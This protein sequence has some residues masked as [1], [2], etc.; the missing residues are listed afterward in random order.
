MTSEKLEYDIIIAGA[1]PAGLACAI[2]LEILGIDNVLVLEKADTDNQTLRKFYKD[3]KRVDRNWQGK[4]IDLIGNIDFKDGTKESTI[5]FFQD[6]IAK[7]QVNV[8]CN[9][10]VSGIQK[11]AQYFNISANGKIY[12]SRFAVICIGNMGKPNKPDYRIPSALKPRVGNNLESC[13]SNEKIMVIGGGDSATEYAYAL[14]D[15]GNE[16][17]LCYRKANI[18][19]ANPTNKSI[20]E[21]YHKA[22]KLDLKLG[23]DIAEVKPNEDKKP[24]VSFKDG[25]IETYDRLIY[26]IG[27]ANPVDFIKSCD[28]AVDD[29]KMAI[30]NHETQES[31]IENL[32]LAGEVV[33]KKGGSVSSSINHGFTIAQCI[34]A[35]L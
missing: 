2:E 13:S 3:G 31:N 5:D 10:E 14:A 35:R 28:V 25:S 6:L 27:G 7:H 30:V 12:K 8:L 16:V 20:I 19:K 4:L 9:S 15:D 26:A 32:F 22:K 1:G 34:K 24:L 17:T 18:T 11:N 21:D 23:L 33:E 29:K